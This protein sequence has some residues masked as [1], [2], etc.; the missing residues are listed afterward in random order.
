MIAGT[1]DTTSTNLGAEAGLRLQL[2]KFLLAGGVMTRRTNYDRSD[3]EGGL[4]VEETDFEFTGGFVELGAR[5]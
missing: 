1:F 5:W 2:G 3:P 4:F